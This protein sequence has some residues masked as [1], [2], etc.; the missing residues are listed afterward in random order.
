MENEYLLQ[1]FRRGYIG[2]LLE[3]FIHARAA[4]QLLSIL[5]AE[6][7]LPHS[8]YSTFWNKRSSPRLSQ[9]QTVLGVH[10]FDMCH[11]PLCL[12]G[13]YLRKYEPR[14]R[15]MGWQQNNISPPESQKLPLIKDVIGSSCVFMWQSIKRRGIWVQDGWA[16]LRSLCN[17]VIS[18]YRMDEAVTPVCVPFLLLRE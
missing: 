8:V 18:I 16:G 4:T 15:G 6:L 3:S 9:L 1:S 5:T 17:G 2:H 13:S 11:E 7:L 10:Y 14:K 12:I